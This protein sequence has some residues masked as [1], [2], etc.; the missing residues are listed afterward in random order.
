MVIGWATDD[1]TGG[2]MTDRLGSWINAV[3]GFRELAD[4]VIAS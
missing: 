4:C 2:A 3:S 1:G